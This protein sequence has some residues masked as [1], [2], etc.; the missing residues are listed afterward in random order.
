MSGMAGCSVFFSRGGKQLGEVS[1]FLSVGGK[2][3]G[4][5]YLPIRVCTQGKMSD[6]IGAK[7]LQALFALDSPCAAEAATAVAKAALYLLR[8][9]T[10]NEIRALLLCTMQIFNAGCL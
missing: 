8:L 10:G 5:V 3:W 9:Q 6:G 2:E 1:G 7:I 4:H